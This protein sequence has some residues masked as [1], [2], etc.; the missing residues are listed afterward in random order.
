MLWCI[1]YYYWKETQIKEDIK[2]YVYTSRIR[3]FNPFYCQICGKLVLTIS[4]GNV[5]TVLI[6]LKMSK[7]HSYNFR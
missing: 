4:T 6:M 7:L 3:F 2:G 1:F 5:A